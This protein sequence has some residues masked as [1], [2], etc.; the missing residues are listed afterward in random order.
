[1][2]NVGTQYMHPKNLEKILK[3]LPSPKHVEVALAGCF[4][5]SD[6]NKQV[7]SVIPSLKLQVDTE[8][9][10]KLKNP[11]KEKIIDI[12]KKQYELRYSETTSG[13]FERMNSKRINLDKI[14]WYLRNDIRIELTPCGIKVEYI[15]REPKYVSRMRKDLANTGIELE[16]KAKNI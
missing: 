9:Y 6:I 2:S 3:H 14:S 13:R 10:F 4:D 16:I 15:G 1:M 7:A 5:Y 11:S 12:Y 8:L